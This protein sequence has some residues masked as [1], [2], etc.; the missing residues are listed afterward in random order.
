MEE[1]RKSGRKLSAAKNALAM[2]LMQ[3]QQKPAAEQATD[4][5]RAAGVK[6][7]DANE[8]SPARSQ[9]QQIAQAVTR[10]VIADPMGALRHYFAREK[11]ANAY[12]ERQR[13]HREEKK[14]G[15]AADGT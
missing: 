10:A 15:T 6:P 11:A 9:N 14:G 3:G 12:H 4:A 8:T 2:Q 5:L 1:M 13:N 7:K